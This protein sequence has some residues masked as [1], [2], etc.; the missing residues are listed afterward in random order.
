MSSRQLA[1]PRERGALLAQPGM[2]TVTMTFRTS[3][4]VLQAPENG[5][6]DQRRVWRLRKRTRRSAAMAD[7][8]LVGG[9][10]RQAVNPQP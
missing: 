1:R 6:C 4:S 5:A 9:H 10:A 8:S 2:D 3:P 7:K